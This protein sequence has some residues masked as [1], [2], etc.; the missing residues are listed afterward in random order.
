MLDQLPPVAT[1]NPREVGTDLV[2]YLAEGFGFSAFA[3]EDGVVHQ[4]YS[5]RG[6]G[7]EFLMSYYAIVDR[8]PNGRDE[9]DG[10]QFW[11]RRHDEYGTTRDHAEG[12]AT[13]L[14]RPPSRAFGL[15]DRSRRA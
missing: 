4:T 6:R 14:G 1:R 10:F 11:I 3:L 9:R 2:S 5:T 7:V 8:A 13:G 12:V 15:V